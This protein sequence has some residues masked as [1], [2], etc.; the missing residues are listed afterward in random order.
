MYT[1]NVPKAA[2]WA[3]GF[4]IVGSAASYEYCQYLRR[5]EKREMK[6]HIEVINS[7]RREH[8]KKLAEEK[9]EQRKKEEEE[10]LAQQKKSWYKFW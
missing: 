8:A 7:G 5:C 9:W 10:R 2:N 4:F 3:A 1:G 6:R